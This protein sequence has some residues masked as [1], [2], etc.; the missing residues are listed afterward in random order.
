MRYVHWHI[1]QPNGDQSESEEHEERVLGSR[2]LDREVQGFVCSDV[3]DLKKA[4]DW[5][6]EWKAL[7]RRSAFDVSGI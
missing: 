4:T 7:I 5:N 2:W 6:P 3:A 1:E